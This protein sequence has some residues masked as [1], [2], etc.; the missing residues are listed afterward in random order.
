MV[1]VTGQGDHNSGKEAPQN[2]EEESYCF[3]LAAIVSSTVN[4]K[5]NTEALFKISRFD[6][7]VD[8]TFDQNKFC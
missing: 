8:A 1:T 3:F 2:D 6:E 7:K 5:K 4:T